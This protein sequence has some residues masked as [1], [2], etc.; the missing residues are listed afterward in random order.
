VPKLFIAGHSDSGSEYLGG[1]H[2]PWPELTRAWLTEVSGQRWELEACRFSPMGSRAVSYLLGAVREANPDVVVIPFS[3]YVCTVRMV[4][5]SVRQRFGERAYRLFLR[6]EHE[7]AARTTQGRLRRTANQQAQNVARR[8]LGARTLTTVEQTISIYEEVLHGLAQM[9]SL[10]VIA[11]A[12][13]RFSAKIQAKEPRLHSI[14]DE[15]N[16]R[17]RVVVEQ[18]HFAWADLEEALRNVPD[19]RVFHHEDGVHTTGAFH[20]VYFGVMRQA[21]AEKPRSSGPSAT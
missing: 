10:Q 1:E 6:T 11:V 2:Q 17:L 3:A 12:D 20:E 8:V 14:F 21:L 9:E 5:E 16:A 4:S 15:M 13:A 19:R 18:H 7:F